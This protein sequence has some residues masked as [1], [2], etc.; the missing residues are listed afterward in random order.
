MR[1]VNDGIGG[2]GVPA[3]SPCANEI[4]RRDLFFI[5]RKGSNN[6]SESSDFRVAGYLTVPGKAQRLEKG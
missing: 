6:D 2:S 4:L 1:R 3:S 5:L